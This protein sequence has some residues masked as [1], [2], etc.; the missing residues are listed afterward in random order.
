VRTACSGAAGEHHGGQF[1]LRIDDTDR[2]PHVGDAVERI[3]G[4]R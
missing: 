2:R 3:D 4:F 1:I